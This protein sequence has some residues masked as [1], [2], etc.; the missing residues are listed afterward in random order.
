[1]FEMKSVLLFG[2][3]IICK[4]YIHIAHS[5][6]VLLKILY[7]NYFACLLYQFLSCIKLY[8]V[9]RCFSFSFESYFCFI[10]FEP[11]F[12]AYTSLEINKNS[13]QPP[14]LSFQVSQAAC[15]SRYSTRETFI[16]SLHALLNLLSNF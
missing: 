15:V 4:S 10:Y 8:Y 2:Y 16:I 7:H 1:M 14:S 9:G 11:L 13:S 6:T 3:R 12:K 5:L